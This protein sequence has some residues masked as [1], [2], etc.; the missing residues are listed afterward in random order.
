[1]VFWHPVAFLYTPATHSFTPDT[2]AGTPRS[3]ASLRELA[4]RGVLTFTCVPPGSGVRIGIDRDLNG[5]LDGDE[6]E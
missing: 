5:V 4:E 2:A 6:E 1:M 3:D